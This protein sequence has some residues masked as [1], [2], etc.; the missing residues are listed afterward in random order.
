MPTPS[1]SVLLTGCGRNKSK[2]GTGRE[3]EVP[4][5]FYGLIIPSILLLVGA[6]GFVWKIKADLQA[7]MN[8][9]KEQWKALS[10]KCDKNCSIVADLHETVIRMEERARIHWESNREK[11]ETELHSPEHERRDDLVLKLVK[12]TITLEEAKELLPLLQDVIWN[13]PSGK[14]SIAALFFMDRV[15]A[16][17]ADKE[18]Q[19]RKG[20]GPC[21]MIHSASQ[22]S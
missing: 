7:H 12:E 15:A 16:V 11:M 22:Q 18:C 2:H 20:S 19:Q 5:V 8:A 17:I 6:C 10:E 9:E 13:G 3:S 1:Y 21:S 4:T 14:K